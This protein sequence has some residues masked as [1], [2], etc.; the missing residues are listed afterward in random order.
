MTAAAKRRGAWPPSAGK[1][2][3]AFDDKLI[4]TLP[5]AVA[6]KRTR[7]TLTTVNCRRYALGL[8]DGRIRSN[9]RNQEP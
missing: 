5:P 8:A 1:P 2:F 7:R 6:A 4:R 9:R 3:S